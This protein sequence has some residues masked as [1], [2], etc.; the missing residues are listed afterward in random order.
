MK[1]N[2]ELRLIILFAAVAGFAVLGAFGF[3]VDAGDKQTVIGA[4]IGAIVAG[5]AAAVLPGKGE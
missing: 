3:A 2:L 5:G 1:L 4:I